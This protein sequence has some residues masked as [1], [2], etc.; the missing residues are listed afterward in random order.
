MKKNCATCTNW[1][2]YKKVT[3]NCYCELKSTGSIEVYTSP[4]EYCI[5]WEKWEHNFKE[6]RDSIRPKTKII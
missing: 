1:K 4:K 5:F 3:K 2:R 6:F